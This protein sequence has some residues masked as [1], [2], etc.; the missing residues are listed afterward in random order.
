MGGELSTQTH[1]AGE[2]CVSHTASIY[3]INLLAFLSP[4]TFLEF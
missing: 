2:I 1:L 4:S 3:V